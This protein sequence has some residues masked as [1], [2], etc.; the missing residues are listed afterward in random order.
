MKD[1]LIFDSAFSHCEFSSIINHSKYFNWNRTDLTKD[2]VVFYTDNSI[3]TAEKIGKIKVAWLIEP[4]EL[5]PNSYNHVRN[6]P[7]EFDYIITYDKNLLYLGEKVKLIPRGCA[8]INEDEFKIYDKDKLVSIV[9]S[10]KRSLIGHTLRHDAITQYRD[11]LELYGNGYNT[12]ANIIS[13]YGDY[14]FTVVIENI[15]KDYMFTEKLVTPLLCGTVPIY[16][17]CP[18]I[19][20]FFNEKGIISF[21]TIEELGAILNDVTIEKYNE[22]LP[23]IQE[24]FE[25][26]K[27]YTLTE[28]NIYEDFLSKI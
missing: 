21:D 16:Y 9:A 28:N 22:M 23:Y 24:N 25:L 1:Y 4:E 8:W 17:G 26:A 19:G 14:R 15:K 13:A 18:S 7:D 3:V 6:N 11:K 2:D 27:K 5:Y 12:V 20:E 10:H